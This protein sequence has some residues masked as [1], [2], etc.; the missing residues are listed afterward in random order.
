LTIL[1]E[2]INFHITQRCNYCCR[3]CFAKYDNHGNE[4]ILEHQIKI[5][6]ELI[7]NG[8]KKINF[9]GGE[10]T[11]VSHLSYLIIHAKEQGAFTSLISNG[12]L[13][14]ENLLDL[15]QDSIDMIGLSIDSNRLEVENA[16]GRT[17]KN[18]DERNSKFSHVNLIKNRAR[19]INNYN[20]PLKINT[21]VTPLNWKE[22][23]TDLMCELKP[24][25]WKVLEIHHING[26]N[27]NFF[28]EIGQLEKWQFQQFLDCHKSLNPVVEDSNII[29]ESYCMIT[30]D[31]RF[32]Q[33]TDDDYQYSTPILEVGALYAFKQI[34]FSQVKYFKREG[35]YFKSTVG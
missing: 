11:L 30:P 27:N 24:K 13:L 15:I 12:T 18:L 1:P 16:L 3:Y 20:I 5:I 17:F 22:N 14:G 26:V 8:C 32:Y 35:D 25:R 9:A 19:L 28:E 34:N 4:L 21:I 2:S 33:D 10:P 31:G 7:E 23:L 29:S 6:N